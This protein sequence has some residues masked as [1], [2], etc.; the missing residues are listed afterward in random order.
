MRSAFEEIAS[1]YLAARAKPLKDHPVAQ[2]LR[3]DAVEAV[4]LALGPIGRNMIVQGS[5]GQGNWAV[6]PWVAVFDP[7][8]TTSATRGHYVVYLFSA[9]MRRLY[10][11]L[12]QGTTAAHDE[13]GSHANAELERRDRKSV[14]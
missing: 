13:F 11:S 2:F 7:V 14:V 5:P 3:H 10:L 12:N 9:D 1:K 6:I 8:V 4:T